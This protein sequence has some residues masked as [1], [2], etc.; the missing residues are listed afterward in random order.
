[1]DLILI[2]SQAFYALLDQTLTHIEENLKH[3]QLPKWL[4]QEQTME[5]LN[6][7]SLTT[8]QSIRNNGL[9]RYTQ[10]MKKLI[11]YD[12]DSVMEYLEKHVRDTF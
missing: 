3:R 2:E 8:M 7:K 12:R 6:I 10:P 5:V 4:S 11:L 1:M 9:I